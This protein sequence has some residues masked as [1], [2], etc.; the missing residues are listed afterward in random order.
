MHYNYDT[1][2]NI[3]MNIYFSYEQTSRLDYNN[4][5]M[6]EYYSFLY[7]PKKPNETDYDKLCR[8]MAFKLPIVFRYNVGFAII[9]GILHSAFA[10]NPVWMKRYMYM[11]PIGMFGLCYEEIGTYL[12]IK[13]YIS[14]KQDPVPQVA[15]ETNTPSLTQVTNKK[16]VK[17]SDEPIA[18]I[19]IE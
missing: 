11:I 13:G 18:R 19:V 3:F 7:T 16:E 8:R 14:P 15:Q 17:Y 1:I 2:E 6:V 10:R 4:W 12:R 5:K 9:L